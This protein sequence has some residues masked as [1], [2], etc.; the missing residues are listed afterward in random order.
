MSQVFDDYQHKEGDHW[1]EPVLRSFEALT[2][3]QTCS[4]ELHIL[5][6]VT[7]GIKTGTITR[8]DFSYTEIA[9]KATASG[10]A[11]EIS[12]ELL[13]LARNGLFTNGSL[14]G[15][16]NVQPITNHPND[17]DLENWQG[18]IDESLFEFHEVYNSP[19]GAILQGIMAATENGIVRCGDPRFVKMAIEAISKCPNQKYACRRLENLA[20]VGFFGSELIYGCEPEKTSAVS[21]LK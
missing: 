18:Q 7:R 4:P 3:E 2:T 9:S 20:E 10:E 5:L 12:C 17:L 13:C 14:P 21:R 6:G 16:E 8:G 19:Q 11:A 1:V 15:S